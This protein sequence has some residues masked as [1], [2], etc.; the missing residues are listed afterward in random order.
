MLFTSAKAAH[1]SF[2]PQGQPERYDRVLNMVAVQDE[3]G[4][5]RLYFRR[6]K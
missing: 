6:L 1:L 5:Q 2:L 3:E 4:F